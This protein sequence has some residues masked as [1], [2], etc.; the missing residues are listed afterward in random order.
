MQIS[1]AGVKHV[2]DPQPVFLRQLARAPEHERKLGA[3]YGAVHA[4]IVGRDAAD[5]RK[6]R[7]APGPEQ[8]PLLLG[9]RCPA[10]HG[11]AIPGDRLDAPDQMIDLRLRAVE[12]DDQQRL[13]VERIAGMHE[14]LDGV[15]RGPVHH[16]H[17]ARNDAGADDPRHAGTRVFR[18]RKADQHRACAFRLL[19]DAHRHFRDH[20]EQS[21]RAGDDTEEVVAAGIEMLAA[22]PDHLAGHQ[23][24]FEAQHVVGGHA[25]F[26]T[27][28]AARILR[29]VAADRAGDLR[30]GIGRVVEP[31][32][33]DRTRDGE[34]GDA[35]LDH[36]DTVLEIDL[37]DAV[38]LG[39]AEK[40]AVA[41]RQ[42]AARQRGAGA[43]RH[44][45]DA[46]R[47]AIGQHAGDL[48]RRRRQHHH[49]RELTI[50]GKP[51]RLVRAHLALGRDHAFARDD[52]AQRVDDFLAARQNACIGYRHHDG[53]DGVPRP[54]WLP[55]CPLIAGKQ[56]QNPANCR[57]R[58][59]GTHASDGALTA[60][61]GASIRSV[62]RREIVP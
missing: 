33:L 15:Y 45:L 9:A 55:A 43:A 42:S 2:G 13:D 19:Q 12:L 26:E 53:H 60:C 32:V 57:I 17:A 48:C 10:G 34:V 25:V 59:I 3:R 7:L 11:A 62:S 6:R 35:G 29:H 37:A 47:V 24:H 56:R 61:A 8:Q 46:V 16:L 5:R 52:R 41:E 18:G 14:L 49:H 39:H 20:A 38:E 50:G 36:C 44:H 27:M 40:H 22:E 21:F 4:I 30:G 31:A 1:V 58:P 23:H 54:R 51:V 28:H